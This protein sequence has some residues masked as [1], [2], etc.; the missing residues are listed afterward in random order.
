M[1]S[2]QEDDVR[3][4]PL[5][6]WHRARGARMVPFAGHTMPV[7]YDGIIAEHLWTRE[8][9]GLFDV[10]HMGQLLVTSQ[11]LAHAQAALEALLPVDLATLATG[12]QRYSLLLDDHGGILDDLIITRWPGAFFVVVNGATRQADIAHIAARLPA[13][14]TLTP[15]EDHGLLALQG[16]RAAGALASLGLEPAAPGIVPVESLWFMAAGPYRWNGADLH[17][18]RSGYSGEDGYEIAVPTGAIADFAD[19]LAAHPAVRPIGLGARDSLRL[20]AGLP[21]YGHD[22]TPDIDPVEAGLGFAI[23]RRRRAEGG[24]PGHARIA[25]ALRDG[26]ARRRVGL[27]IEG[28]LAAREGAVVLAAGQPIGSV[29]SGG[30]A[31]S[32]GHPIAM[33]LIDAAHAATGT[34]LGIDLRGRQIAARVVAM[35]FV[36]H[37]YQRKGVA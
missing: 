15:R 4:L 30:F 17:V 9:A 13:G 16:P 31:P 12:G 25:A 2:D 19:A 10:S 8:N 6:A 34:V 18:S 33:A 28:R 36:P 32:L 23:A 35:P 29:T 1:L 24:F 26:P 14:V 20:E 11:D 21:L 22:L 5:D 3:L 37:R 27:A 7:Q